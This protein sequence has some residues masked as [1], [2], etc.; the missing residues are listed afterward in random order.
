MKL[1]TTLLLAFSLCAAVSAGIQNPALNKVR[2]QQAEKHAPLEL[3]KNGKLNFVIAYDKAAEKHLRYSSRKSIAPAIEALQKNIKLATGQTPEAVDVTQAEPHKGKYLLLVGESALTRKLGIKA[4]ALPREGFIVKSFSGGIAIVGND[5]SI[6]K[7][8]HKGGAMAQKGARRA[9]LWGAYDFL[10]RFFGCRFYFPGKYGSL[11]PEVKQLTVAPVCYI[12]YSRFKNRGVYY[13]TVKPKEAEKYLGKLT[14][15]DLKEYYDF[16]RQAKTEPYTGMH[17]PF[18]IPWSKANPEMIESSFF[19][20]LYGHRY[21]STVSHAANYFDVT[22]LKFA[23]NLIDSLKRYYKSNGKEK[24]G[25]GY[26]NDYYIVF[27]QAD[28]EINVNEMQANEV[29]KRE[30]LIT[31]AH[32][33]GSYGQSY[34]DIYAR[35]YKYLAEWIKK[36]FPGKKLIVM[37]YNRYTRA[38]LNP[39]YYLPDNVELSVCLSRAPRWLRNPKVKKEYLELM[40]NWYKALG[41]RPVQQLWTYSAGSNAFVHGI[42]LELLGDVPKTFGKYLG[43][44]EIFHELNLWPNPKVPHYHFYYGNYVAQ[45]SVWNPDFDGQAAIDE[46]WEPFYGK[47]AGKHLRKLHKVL[48]DAYFKYACPEEQIKPLYPPAVLSQMEKLFNAAEKALKKDSI[49]W[50]RYEIFAMPLKWEL[51]VQQRR[52]SYNRPIYPVVQLLSSD[53]IVI[54]GKAEDPVWKKARI[55]PLQDPTGSGEKRKFP[56]DFRLAWG[57]NGIYGFMNMPHKPKCDKKDI[58][59]N[60]VMELFI[61]P[62]R[63]QDFY[64][65]FAFDPQKHTFSLRRQIEPFIMAM[66]TTWK[67][68]GLVFETVQTDKGWTME[69]FI[70][71]SGLAVKKPAGYES[72]SFSF[73]YTKASAPREISASVMNLGN[74]HNFN[75]YGFIKFLGKGD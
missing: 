38:P 49:E 10:E 22:N 75:M 9:T 62:G 47:K 59:S 28:T 74:N 71:F 66:D 15:A 68:K 43:D 52:H 45:R 20:N 31:Q 29:V 6:D 46:H 35:F 56:P 25:W 19:K 7:T 51:Q 65:Q 41:N 5:S 39:K 48:W 53:K 11:H 58:W 23:D 32:L 55:M 40:E 57:E 30:K 14:N 67:C 21:H 72:W 70:P 18:P 8:F 24:Q 37:P 13:M 26:N 27:G 2:F 36:E 64:V 17:S 69:F 73:V 61:F 34:S 12:D 3:V 54:D 1:F 33:D 60:D 44:V 16:M 63:K 50:K 4:A 42:S